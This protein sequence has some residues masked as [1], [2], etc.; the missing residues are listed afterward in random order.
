MVL[1]LL[2]LLV[3]AVVGLVALQILFGLN[4]LKRLSGR[5]SVR[6]IPD[7]ADP[8][9]V[10]GT[11]GDLAEKVDE[12]RGSLER[13]EEQLRTRYPVLARMLSGYLHAEGIQAAG[14]LE[15]AVKEMILDWQGEREAVVT[16]IA[17]VLAENENEDSVRAIIL[18]CCDL[19]LTKEGY[20]NWLVWVQGQF[21]ALS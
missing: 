2:Y 11:G 5:G 1:Q 12:L 7:R 15:S 16:E 9:E 4:F 3:L 21:S 20:R 19:D 17:R 10:G 6:Q 18:A 13:A 8:V 14:G